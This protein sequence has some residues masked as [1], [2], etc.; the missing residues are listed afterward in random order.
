MKLYFKN[1][2]ILREK[3]GKKLE[4]MEGRGREDIG[5]ESLEKILLIYL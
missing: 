1:N 5:R 3:D 4:M 2:L